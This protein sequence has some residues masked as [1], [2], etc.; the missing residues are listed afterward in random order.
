MATTDPSAVADTLD[1]AADA[2]WMYGRNNNPFGLNESD[3]SMCVLGAVAH[4]KGLNPLDW[5]WAASTVAKPEHDAIATQI[6]ADGHAPAVGCMVVWG[7]N[8]TTPLTPEGDA[9]V[10]DTVRKAAKSLR[11]G[12]ITL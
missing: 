5:S 7:F 8:D 4:V 3:G 10:I 12:E 6:V 2:L 9:L 11:N 1:A